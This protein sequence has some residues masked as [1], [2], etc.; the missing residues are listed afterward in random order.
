MVGELDIDNLTIGFD[1]DVEA[2]VDAVLN[3]LVQQASDEGTGEIWRYCE[4]RDMVNFSRVPRQEADSMI[5]PVALNGRDGRDVLDSG[6]HGEVHSGF[7]NLHGIVTRNPEVIDYAKQRPLWTVLPLNWDRT[8]V[9]VMP[10]SSQ[11]EQSVF[12]I[13][14]ASNFSEYVVPAA[15]RA[16]TSLALSPVNNRCAQDSPGLR[17]DR[18][19][20]SAS[21][22]YPGRDPVAQAIAER[23]AAIASGALSTPAADS[24]RS[25]LPAIQESKANWSAIGLPSINI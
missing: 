18:P 10:G 25:L 11:E 14:L 19:R 1:D 7:G 16:P 23:M 5:L 21:I 12:P 22:A 15:S 13:T 4:E 9:L 17:A 6:I 24:L 8:Y 2:G 20:P 3:V